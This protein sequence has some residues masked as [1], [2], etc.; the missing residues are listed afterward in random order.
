MNTVKNI[1]F[2]LSTI[3][4]Y[5]SSDQNE[6]GWIEV[7]NGSKIEIKNDCIAI[8]PNNTSKKLT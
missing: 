2:K 8:M 6:F 1:E 4:I 5:V 3:R 7:K